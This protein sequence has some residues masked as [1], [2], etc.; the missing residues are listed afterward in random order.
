MAV[1]IARRKLVAL[2]IGAAAFGGLTQSRLAR[3]QAQ[4]YRLAVVAGRARDADI[5]GTFFDELRL[6]GIVEGQNLTVLP[7]G[8]GLRNEQFAGVAAAVVNAAPHV[9][10]PSGDLAARIVQDATHAI[11]IVAIT[12]DMIAAGLVRSLA[13]PGGNITGV[14]LLSVELNGKRLE[15]LMEA[16]PGARRIATLSDANSDPKKFLALQDAVRS[17][18]IEL[19]NYA[20]SSPEGIAPA[21]DAAKSWGATALN[22][23]ATQFFSVNRHVVIDRA[24]AARLPAIY[25]WPDMAEDG[26][27]IGYGPR[28]TTI[29]RQVARQVVKILQGVKPADL[30]VEQPTTFEFVINLKTAKAIGHEVPASLVARADQVIE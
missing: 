28:L 4:T 30:P 25:Q 3:G 8:F 5:F 1:T 11:P 24:N 14:S 10:V 7:G 18:G 19:A 29:Y 9:I 17:R 12:D 27:L 13:R 23:L 15:I 16:A 2:G 6:S 26:G 20:V 21:I 22:V